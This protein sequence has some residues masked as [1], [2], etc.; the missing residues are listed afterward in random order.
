MA[1]R[2]ATLALLLGSEVAAVLVLHRLGRVDGLGGPGTDP[3]GWLRS[4]SPE[5]VVAGG[6][7]LVA[8]VCACWLLASTLL[9]VVACTS[10]LPVAVR[11]ARAAVLPRIRHQVDRALAASVVGASIVTAGGG[12][13]AGDELPP[14]TTVPPVVVIAQDQRPAPESPLPAPDVR[15]GRAVE[16]LPPMP[17]APEPTP[18]PEPPVPPAPP[19]SAEPPAPPPPSPPPAAP[20]LPDAHVVMPGDNLWSITAA[21]VGTDDRNAVGR[22]WARLVSLNRATLRSGDPDLIY[23]GET[24]QLPPPG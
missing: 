5:E 8:L 7:R 20:A 2:T 13:A 12:A 16:A 3:I 24:L 19:P 23:P 15:Q 22:Y 14:P 1:R 21:R 4:A 11:A 10:R 6:S 9:Y 18:P 17:P